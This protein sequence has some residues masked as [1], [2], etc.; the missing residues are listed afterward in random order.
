MLHGTPCEG[1]GGEGRAELNNLSPQ[2]YFLVGLPSFLFT[3]GDEQ[4]GDF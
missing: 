3:G 4:K 2:A 1:E